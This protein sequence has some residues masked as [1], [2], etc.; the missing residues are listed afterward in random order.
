MNVFGLL[1]ILTLA[2]L[3]SGCL[4]NF[5]KEKP[6]VEAQ[7]TQPAVPDVPDF[8][9]IKQ[10]NDDKRNQALANLYTADDLQKA[11]RAAALKLV[12]RNPTDPEIAQARK[13]LSEY[14]KVVRTYLQDPKFVDVMRAYFRDAMQMAGVVGAINYNEPS[15]LLT[16]IVAND[17][18]YRE[19][20]TATYCVD[21]TLNKAASCAAFSKPGQGS[22]EEFGAGVLTT[23]AFLEKWKSAFNFRRTNRA[24]QTFACQE[25][26]NKADTGMRVEHISGTIA[27]FN[28]TAGEPVCFN[29]HKSINPVA[30]LFYKFDRKG[31]LNNN[32]SM[33]L[34]DNEVT[35]RVKLEVSSIDDILVGNPQATYHNEPIDTVRDYAKL[36]A[37]NKLFRNCVAQRFTNFIFG[38]D[39]MEKL[40]AELDYLNDKVIDNGYKIRPL[41]EEVLKSRLFVFVK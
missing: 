20:I 12:S 33:N 39:H 16:Y 23:Q 31:F 19:S 7:D 4:G 15:N 24:F 38:N 3:N 5:E 40:P 22:V 9:E 11:L 36:F 1:I 8:D 35:Q 27:T 25:Y 13:G 28:A 18:D 21:D 17:L 26:P 2:S 37:N 32:P 29:C 41:P 10:D 14:S 34:A 30:S 6:K